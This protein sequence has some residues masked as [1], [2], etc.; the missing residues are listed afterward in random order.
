MFP[1]LASS[2]IKKWIGEVAENFNLNDELG[3]FVTVV[4]DGWLKRLIGSAKIAELKALLI[5]IRAKQANDT[6]PTV[7]VTD[8]QQ[9]YLD[10]LIPFIAYA[11]WTDYIARGHI[12]ITRSGPVKK[13]MIGEVT[14]LDKDER[15]AL[16]NIYLAKAKQ[17]AVELSRLFEAEKVPTCYP[18][19]VGAKNGRPTVTVIR[20]KDNSIFGNR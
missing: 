15:K 14:A 9:A 3:A 20:A 5:L 1:Y 19:N 4:V 16:E 2:D 18:G 11:A 6:L 17:E 13:A 10:S 8:E 7:T 12:K